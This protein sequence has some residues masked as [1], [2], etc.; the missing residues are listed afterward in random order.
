[1]PWERGKMKI[2][3]RI[4]KIGE[5]LAAEYLEKHGY[6]IITIFILREVKLIL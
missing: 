3:N 4:G 2:N 5:K 6:E 1:M